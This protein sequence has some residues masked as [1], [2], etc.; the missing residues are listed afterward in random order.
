MKS[1]STILCSLI[2]AISLT[3][4]KSKEQKAAELIRV[5]LS[6]TLLDFNSYEPIETI[7]TEAYESAYNN[8]WCFHQAMIIAAHMKKA[9]E[10]SEEMSHAK[11]HMEIWGAPS[12]YSSSYSDNQY[13]KYRNQVKENLD[14]LET[15]ITTIQTL[16][17]TLQDSI[18]V[19]NPDKMIGWEVKHRFRC[20]TRGGQAAIGDYRYIV[21]DQ[22]KNILFHEDMDDDDYSSAREIIMNAENNVFD[23][24]WLDK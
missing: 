21:D 7:V 3:A 14:K 20:K 23:G 2:L 9:N 19:F 1:Y 10:Y 8:Y 11:D 6:K 13:Y 18:K 15:E 17:Q 16:G 5:E 4:C 22:F 12:Y 24:N